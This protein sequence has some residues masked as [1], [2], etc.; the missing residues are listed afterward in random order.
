MQEG[1]YKYKVRQKTN[2][3]SKNIQKD[4]NSKANM[5][6]IMKVIQLYPAVNVIHITTICQI[7]IQL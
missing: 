3:T 6:P 2:I 1:K 4:F 7:Q 5:K